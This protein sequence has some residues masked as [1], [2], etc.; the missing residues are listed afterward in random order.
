[1]V[2]LSH[3]VLILLY[4][5]LVPLSHFV[6]SL[7][8]HSSFITTITFN[9]ETKQESLM[10]NAKFLR[11]SA[12]ATYLFYN[13]SGFN[14]APGP[15]EVFQHPTMG[16]FF[17]TRTF[18]RFLRG[19]DYPVFRLLT[20]SSYDVH[21]GVEASGQGSSIKALFIVET[22]N[23]NTATQLYQELREEQIQMNYGQGSIS[24]NIV[25]HSNDDTDWEHSY[26]AFCYHC[27]D[28]I[29]LHWVSKV[30]AE[31]WELRDISL[32][33][34]SNGYG[35]AALVASWEKVYTQGGNEACS[36]RGIM[37]CDSSEALIMSIIFPFLQIS[38]SVHHPQ[39]PFPQIEIETQ[40]SPALYD[41]AKIIMHT[42]HYRQTVI[43]CFNSSQLAPFR[44][45]RHPAIFDMKMFGLLLL[46]TAFGAGLMFPRSFRAGLIYLMASIGNPGISTR[47]PWRALKMGFFVAGTFISALFMACM[48][49][50]KHHAGLL[51]PHI[52]RLVSQYGYKIW[53]P[54]DSHFTAKTVRN[55]Y[56]EWY[57][58][59]PLEDLLYL[60]NDEDNT[61]NVPIFLT[62]NKLA[63][64]QPDPINNARRWRFG[65]FCVE[66]DIS[67]THLTDFY[68]GEHKNIRI[69]GYL[70]N[71]IAKYWQRLIEFG[72]EAK[73]VANVKAEEENSLFQ[74]G[75]GGNIVVHPLGRT[76]FLGRVMFRCIWIWYGVIMGIY[77]VLMTLRGLQCL[78]RGELVS[79]GKG[80]EK[81]TAVTTAKYVG[82]DEN[83]PTGEEEE[84]RSAPDA[85]IEDRLT[86][87]P[88]LPVASLDQETIETE[89][90]ESQDIIPVPNE[91]SPTSSPE[92]DSEYSK[93]P[94]EVEEPER[95]RP[96]EESGMASEQLRNDL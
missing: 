76:S 90:H 60:G 46:A 9:P 35:V 66:H 85:K 12:G 71:E 32:R 74:G 45:Y 93:Y 39:N 6:C 67:Y 10:A 65:H 44:Y 3:I 20:D 18:T 63:M 30:G 68:P 50:N 69:S 28:Q 89:E 16:D 23:R 58:R 37:H 72:M 40:S 75:Q 5:L 70:S 27:L 88:I 2:W 7:S 81:H 94:Q 14:F 8:N 92:P 38:L 21:Q 87:P 11:N 80:S 54:K 52:T 78:I 34:N 4:F 57:F 33:L 61:T 48:L 1:M 86:E 84:E 25:L 56:A 36:K 15:D 24:T 26:L 17:R 95:S 22:S 96:S 59:V 19:S 42:K 73:F 91:R 55:N 77:V 49:T 41:H 82:A 47:R 64:L 31:L 13:F 79:F 83:L 43:V 29:N 62:N 53:I 51:I